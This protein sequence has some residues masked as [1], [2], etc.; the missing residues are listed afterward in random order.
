M[1][2][3]ITVI[4]A[5]LTLISLI[6]NANSLYAQEAGK[7]SSF[8]KDYGW[9]LF[10]EG[11][12]TDAIHELKKSLLADP[13]NRDA[14]QTLDKVILICRY[15]YDLSLCITKDPKRAAC[16]GMP[17]RLELKGIPDELF[18]SLSFNWD[19]GDGSRKCNAKALTHTYARRGNYTVCVE[20]TGKKQYYILKKQARLT[21][22][23][24]TPPV[25]RIKAPPASCVNCD[26][27]FDATDSID[28]DS[29][30]LHFFWDLGDKT[31]ATG[32]RVLHRYSGPGTY[33]VRLKA[34]DQ[35]G[36]PCSVSEISLPVSVRGN[37]VAIFNIN[38]KQ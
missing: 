36:S 5:F 29:D 17:V 4:L 7:V 26:I 32:P 6:L 22:R 38:P 16:I 2:R 8:L 33:T 37:P 25:A 21:L 10:Q 23:V 9:Q 34:L 27:S 12:C 20:V 15:Q 35:C 11:N 1:P 30:Q 18:P 19:F 13:F 24:N 31:I 3:L 28:Q 14:Q